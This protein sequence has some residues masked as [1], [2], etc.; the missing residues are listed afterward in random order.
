MDAEMIERVRSFNRTVTERV[1]ALDEHYL[2]FTRGLGAARVLWE[3]G[4]DGIEV[5]ELRRRLGLDSGYTSRLLRALEGQGLLSV[6]ATPEDRRVRRARLT[7]AGQ[8]ERDRL[9]RRSD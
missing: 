9:D 4:A 2:G 7:A 5:R 3:T 8:A 1:G 6:H